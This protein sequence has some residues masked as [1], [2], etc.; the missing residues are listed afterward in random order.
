MESLK[1]KDVTIL[2]SRDSGSDLGYDICVRITLIFTKGNKDIELQNRN[3]S[4]SM[5]MARYQYY[6]PLS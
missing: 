1:W 2:V 5:L 3:G 4:F 6:C